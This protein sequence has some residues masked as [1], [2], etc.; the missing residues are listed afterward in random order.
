MECVSSLPLD[1]KEI[2]AINKVLFNKRE[3]KYWERGG[4]CHL[5][6]RMGK[7]SGGILCEGICE[8]FEPKQEG[9]KDSQ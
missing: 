6:M 5:K 9:T 1:K 7:F 2:R 8:A 4:Y 3:C